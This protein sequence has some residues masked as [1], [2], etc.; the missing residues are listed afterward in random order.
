MAHAVTGS[1]SCSRRRFIQGMGLMG[2][3]PLLPSCAESPP[4]LH[5]ASGTWQG[6]EPL[7]LA[8]RQGWTDPSVAQL[9]EFPSNAGSLR[10]LN[11]GIVDGAALTLDEVLRVRS[12]GLA[13]TI[14]LV[15]NI[16]IGADMVLSRPDITE[17]AQL[18]GRRIGRAEGTNSDL[19][20]AVLLDRAGLKASDV[21][22]QDVVFGDHL[23]AWQ[24]NRVDALI[25]YDPVAS[26]LMEQG[27][28]RLF[29]TSQ[30]PNTIVDVLALRS[31]I[32][33]DP[34]RKP[35]IEALIR[36]HFRSLKM[37]REQPQEA[38]RLMAD[39]LGLP[40]SEVMDSYQGISQP[41]ITANQQLLSPQTV[42]LKRS[43]EQLMAIMLKNRLLNQADD[44]QG[45][46]S[47]RFLPT[48]QAE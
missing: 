20:L 9:E 7:F 28:Y 36:G 3:M 41:D 39:H 27:A 15:F 16:S 17:L 38:A 1:L 11:A 34:S 30:A 13:L 24:D 12:R 21:Q 4:P 14:V 43:A 46:I 47:N 40:A 2:L 6:Y 32:V 25:T 5:I 44:L 29:D 31:E 19:L 23:T 48:A 22:L 33:G 37:M 8:Q 10:A 35:S 26:Q 45:L 42:E 18:K